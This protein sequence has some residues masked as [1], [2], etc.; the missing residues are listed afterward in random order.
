MASPILVLADNTVDQRYFP[1]ILEFCK[2]FATYVQKPVD[3]GM[4]APAAI[5]GANTQARDLGASV[6]TIE[7]RQSANNVPQTAPE[8]LWNE[9][10]SPD[11][12]GMW[13]TFCELALYGGPSQRGFDTAIPAPRPED[14][15]EHSDI[16]AVAEIQR[17][18]WETT[19]LDSEIDPA[20]PGWLKVL[21]Y[22]P[23]MAAWLAASIILENVSARCQDEFLY[24]PASAG[25]TLKD[26]VV[27]IIS[28]VAKTNHYWQEF[29]TAQYGTG[30]GG[31]M[32]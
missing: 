23:K 11:W 22:G 5:E 14:L 29:I 18:I 32:H 17:G 25:F 9:D 4:G 1:D 21:T 3:L 19:G 13:I 15:R 20:E 26:E 27:S 7:P 8:F 2:S 31:H 30:F 10:G 16:D 12:G 24:V 6:A 28:V